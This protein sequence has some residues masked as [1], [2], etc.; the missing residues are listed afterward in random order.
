MSDFFAT[1]ET[2]KARK[3]HT[4]QTCFRK[5][6]IGEQYESRFGIDDG[7]PH[8]FKRC[9]HCVAVWSIWEPEDIDGLISDDGYD[10]WASSDARDLHE[11]RNMVYFR[12]QW[13]RKDGTLYP[14]PELAVAP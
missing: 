3:P 5:I 1:P 6:D 4:C 9:A 13:R 8:R 2:R 12:R 11:L 7:N 14:L 10:S